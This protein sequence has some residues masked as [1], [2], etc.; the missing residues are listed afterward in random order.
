MEQL[1]Q[2]AVLLR[3]SCQPKF[4]LTDEQ[5]DLIRDL[6]LPDYKE[7]KV[8][9]YSDTNKTINDFTS[10]F[11]CYLN[12]LLEMLGVMKKGKVI[13]DKAIK[14]AETMLPLEMKDE[15]INGVHICKDV[16][17]PKDPCESG[18]LIAKCAIENIPQ[19]FLP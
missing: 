11:Q 8:S 13:A 9:P 7:G 10:L 14:T 4:K 15:F 12:C 16:P 2:T 18:L 17:L 6:Q 1:H 19:L 5:A 3:Q